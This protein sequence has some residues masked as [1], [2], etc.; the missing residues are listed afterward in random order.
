MEHAPSFAPSSAGELQPDQPHDDLGPQADP[1]TGPGASRR[2]FLAGT[3]AL[4]VAATTGGTAGF[5]LGRAGGSGTSGGPEAASE[6]TVIAYVR[7]GESEVTVMSG[8][9]EVVVDDPAL[10]RA[11]ARIVGER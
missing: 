5:R 2:F 10:A 3:G 6:G 7:P 4:A 11:L 8:D 1:G 9:R